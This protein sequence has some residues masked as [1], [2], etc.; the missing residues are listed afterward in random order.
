MR[1]SSKSTTFRTGNFLGQKDAK[2]ARIA[3]RAALHSPR[4]CYVCFTGFISIFSFETRMSRAN[5]DLAVF[6]LAQWILSD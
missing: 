5:L 6:S 4:S 3:A 2:D 1:I